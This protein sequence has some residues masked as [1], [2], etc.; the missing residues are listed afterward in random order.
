[1]IGKVVALTVGLICGA[2]L[3]Q[4]PE[5]VQQYSQRL[6]GRIDE[7]RGFVER[8]DADASAAGLSRIEALAEYQTQPSRFV[9]LRGQDAA[10]TIVRYE[11][12]LQHRAALRE[13]GPFV[14]LWV[15]AREVEPDIAEATFADYEPAVPVTLEGAAHAGA[16][17]LAGAFG[18]GLLGRAFATR[19][20]RIARA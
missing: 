14:R 8:F 17:F 11:A 10:A 7:L 1:M 16:G 13:A 9:T 2:A 3:S 5:F 20:R 19:R 15:F 18:A 4:G 12:Y 6:G